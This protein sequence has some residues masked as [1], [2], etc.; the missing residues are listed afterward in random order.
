MQ[1]IAVTVK[2]A[3]GDQSASAARMLQDVLASFSQRLNDLLGG[4]ISGLSELNRNT[5]DSVQ[6]AVRSLGA[7]TAS[8]E[9]ASE[10]SGDAMAARMAEAMEKMERRQDSIN[11]QTTAFVDQLRQL[12]ATSQSA[13]QQQLS[14]TLSRLGAQVADVV[15]SLREEHE[16][17][18]EMQHTRESVLAERTAG[19]VSTMT[20]S[21]DGAVAAMLSASQR[22]Q[23]SVATIAQASTT[24]IDRMTYG[25]DTLLTASRSFADAGDRVTG[26]MM[27]ASA[28]AGKLAEL[29]GALTASSSALQRA[30]ADYGAQRDA[31]IAL[32]RDLK[33]V[34]AVARTEASLTADV[35]ARLEGAAQKLTTAQSQAERYLDQVS[36][37]LAE[38]HSAF[39]D[40]THRT[41]ER[42]NTDFHNKLS[43]AVHMLSSTIQELDT[44]IGGR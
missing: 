34:V 43:N 35:L 37:V 2:Q 14:D 29:S 30:V 17:T 10:R 40:A 9:A 25:A 6:Q 44:T 33:D 39:A 23:E 24:T 18:V 20:G 7:L 12:V 3:S 4:Q 42:A 28:V 8:I 19:A 21:V 1:E 16:R 32:V 5:A 27:Q 31:M 15:R 13:S 22:M 41:L 38:A 11:A 26:V 36:Q